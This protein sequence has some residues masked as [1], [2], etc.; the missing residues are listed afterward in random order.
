MS[1]ECCYFIDKVDSHYLR[2][3]SDVSWSTN[4]VD[5]HRYVFRANA[6]KEAREIYAT[7]GLSARVVRLVPRN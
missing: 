7:H 1:D 6:W 3:G 4:Q 2:S 5:A